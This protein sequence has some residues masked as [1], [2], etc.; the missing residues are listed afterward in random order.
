LAVAEDFAI[1]VDFA[2]LRR[3]DGS[4]RTLLAWGDRVRVL[5]RTATKVEVEV[6]DFKE[7][8]DGSI[9][10]VAASGFLK[11][12]LRVDGADRQVALPVDDV[13]VLQVAFVDVQ[14][15]DGALVQTPSGKLITID[16][17]ENQLFA[18][19]LAGRLRDTSPAARR[20]IDAMVVTHGDADHFAGLSKIRESETEEGLADHKRLFIH[21]ERVFHNGLVKRPSSVPELE[22]LG[23]TKKAGGQTILTGLLDNPLDVPR[24][25][26]EQTLQGVAEGARRMASGRTHRVP[27][28]GARHR[29][30][31]LVP[32]A[33]RWLPRH[34][35]KLGTRGNP[36]V[37]LSAASFTT[38]QAPQAEGLPG[39]VR[40]AMASQDQIQA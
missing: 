34:A 10:P 9:R 2:V 14:Q 35:Q 40:G 24:Q 32:R 8:P 12:K 39:M 21:P 7:Q 31:R 1:N 19:F 23:P 33:R 37:L 13:R 20:R 6:T 28:A 5:D 3:E 38:P 17:G 30:R 15:G 36:R 18:R 25:R 26:H 29:R 4:P 16:G 11:R 27:A 22:Q